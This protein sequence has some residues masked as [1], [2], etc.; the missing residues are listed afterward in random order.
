MCHSPLKDKGV[1]R[2]SNDFVSLP[3]TG[4][5][6]RF[7]YPASQRT[8]LIWVDDAAEVYARLADQP[9]LAHAMYNTG[10]Y[11]V[12]LGELAELVRAF[13]PDAVHEF[14]AEGSVPPQPMPSRVSG[15]RA[16]TDLGIAS[17]P[18]VETLPIHADRARKLAAK[19][20]G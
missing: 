20:A 2:W 9:K 6:M 3:A 8:S 7:P 4:R 19:G 18:L 1:S 15:A 12:S 17:A 13:I 16:A 11:D 14:A 5:A 10:G